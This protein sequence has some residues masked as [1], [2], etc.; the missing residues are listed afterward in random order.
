MSVVSVEDIVGVRINNQVI[1]RKCYKDDL[2]TVKVREMIT[3]DEIA[4]T[5][6]LYCDECKQALV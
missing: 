1:C 2:R 5:N 3:K 4:G 6:I